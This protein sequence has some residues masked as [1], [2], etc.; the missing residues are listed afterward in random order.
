MFGSWMLMFGVAS[1]VC[2]SFVRERQINLQ[3]APGR[4]SLEHIQGEIQNL[5]DRSN[6]GR[7][8][9]KRAWR[10]DF[11]R[12]GKSQCTKGISPCRRRSL[13]Q[14]DHSIYSDFSSPL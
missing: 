9:D 1:A 5:H 10:L 14:V 2:L 3:G 7:P 4:Q 11:K 12:K 8:S 13:K 6:R